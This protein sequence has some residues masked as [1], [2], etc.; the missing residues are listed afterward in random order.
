VVQ[1]GRAGSAP[2]HGRG[3]VPVSAEVLEAG[4][5]LDEPYCGRLPER[6]G[7]ERLPGEE[8]GDELLLLF[9]C[10][11]GKSLAKARIGPPVPRGRGKP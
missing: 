10:P 3:C 2:W 11:R 6:Y 5:Y 1:R 8:S 9:S 7:S 4:G